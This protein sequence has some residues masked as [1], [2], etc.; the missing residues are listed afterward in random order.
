MKVYLYFAYDIQNKQFSPQSF[1]GQSR[2]VWLEQGSATP[3]TRATIGTRHRNQWHTR[4]KWNKCANYLHFIFGSWTRPPPERVSPLP[5]EGSHARNAAPLSLTPGDFLP[6]SSV[7]Q[8][9]SFHHRGKHFT[10]C[11]T[12]KELY[13][14][15]SFCV[16]V[17]LV[18]SPVAI[19]SSRI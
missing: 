15:R 16:T 9:W 3:G 6:L 10:N 2:S 13:K 5:A 8:C 11:S 18:E 12:H 4:N 1:L 7:V 19:C 14:C 17:S